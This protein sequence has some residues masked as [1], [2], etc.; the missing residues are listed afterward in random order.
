MK[1]DEAIRILKIC[2]EDAERLREPYTKE[3][4]QLGIEAL[5][6]ELQS[7]T[8]QTVWEIRKLP[9]ETEE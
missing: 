9:G 3:A 7:R 4:I 1:I 8:V 2:I 6:R 5:K